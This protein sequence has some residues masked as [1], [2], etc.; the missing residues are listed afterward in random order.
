MPNPDFRDFD[1]QLGN[2]AKGF[3][4]STPAKSAAF[5]V[6]TANWPGLA[7]KS[8]PNRSAGVKKLKIHAT[9]EGL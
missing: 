9:S 5:K 2:K 6:G 1:N 4:R 8:G 7:G 3:K